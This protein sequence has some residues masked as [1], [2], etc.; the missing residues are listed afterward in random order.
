M[1]LEHL[2]LSWHQ[3]K[4]LQSLST[5]VVVFGRRASCSLLLIWQLQVLSRTNPG[6][7]I[8]RL[9]PLSSLLL[10]YFHRLQKVLAHKLSDARVYEPQIRARLGTT[11]HFCKVAV[12]EVCPVGRWEERLLLI[13][14]HPESLAPDHAPHQSGKAYLSFDF[15]Y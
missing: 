14:S 15:V 11:A 3:R 6:T 13:A 9:R 10:L 5:R 2:L 12:V 7:R 1:S 4:L 8:S